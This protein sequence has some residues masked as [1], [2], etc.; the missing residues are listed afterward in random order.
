MKIVHPAQDEPACS[1][2]TRKFRFDQSGRC[3][4]HDGSCSHSALLYM[5]KIDPVAESWLLETLEDG[6]LLHSGL[7]CYQ[8]TPERVRRR[9]MRIK[10]QESL[11]RRCAVARCSAHGTLEA[12]EANSSVE[13]AGPWSAKY[14]LKKNSVPISKCEAFTTSASQ[15]Q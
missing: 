15:S 6:L 13:Y 1:L 3:S 4:R 2:V 12:F 5:S 14:K 8:I 9:V 10:R 7:Q 11:R